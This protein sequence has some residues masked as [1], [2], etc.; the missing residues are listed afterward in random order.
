MFSN[1]FARANDL[2]VRSRHVSGPSPSNLPILC[3]SSGMD[4]QERGRRDAAPEARARQIIDA[5]LA[6]AGWIVQDRGE[7]GEHSATAHT[8]SL[9]DFV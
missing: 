5:G 4:G 6:A 3:Y 8:G 2:V 9:A 1:F 7:G